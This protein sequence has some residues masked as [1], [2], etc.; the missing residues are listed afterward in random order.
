MATANINS[1]GTLYRLAV[2]WIVH[3]VYDVVMVQ[4]HRVAQPSSIRSWADKLAK[5]GWASTWTPAEVTE[6]STSGGTAIL[7]RLGLPIWSPVI[8]E[9][10]VRAVGRVATAVMKWPGWKPITLVSMYLET[11]GK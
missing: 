3:D 11:G 4:E 10:V 5:L 8:Q 6:A 7:W 9:N 2:E 1:V